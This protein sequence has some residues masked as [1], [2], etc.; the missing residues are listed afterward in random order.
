MKMKL[1]TVTLKRFDGDPCNCWD[2][3]STAVDG[4][5]RMPEILK[6]HHLNSLLDGKAAA[7][8]TGLP[9]S[10]N[11]YKETIQL[12][13]DRFG[14]KEQIIRSHM[15]NIYNLPVIKD[16]DIK[17]LREMFDKMES[18]VRGLKTLGVETEQY[19]ILL[20]PLLQPKIP[21]SIQIEISRKCANG[22]WI[23]RNLMAALKSPTLPK[24]RKIA[25]LLRLRVVFS[26]KARTE[27]VHVK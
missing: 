24:R 19:D 1:P 16:S 20:L 14:Q 4:E 21:E 26:V 9:I 22:S 8:I 10:A 23:L 15:E 17:R 11:N 6:Y 27:M 25:S 3:F 5:K 13:Q 7:T 12:L 2:S 18:H